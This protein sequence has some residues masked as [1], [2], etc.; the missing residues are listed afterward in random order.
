MNHKDDVKSQLEG[1]KLKQQM[2]KRFWDPQGNKEVL[3]FFVEIV[4]RLVESERCSIF[5]HDPTSQEVWLQCGTGLDEKQIVLPMIGSHV[6]EVIKSGQARMFSGHDHRSEVAKK[7]ESRT[8]FVTRSMLC[9]PIRTLGDDKVTGAIQV[10]NKRGADSFTEEDRTLLERVAEHLE[11][12]IQN[13]YLSH[14][15]ACVSDTLCRRASVAEW[16]I[17][18]WMGVLGVI[19][20]VVFGVLIYFTPKVMSVFMR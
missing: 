2:L 5:I 12:V 17:K 15:M 20:A 7:V 8:G 11:M 10:L 3:D 16:A 6:G 9:V 13:I 18:L 19:I 14:Q 4:P 1:L